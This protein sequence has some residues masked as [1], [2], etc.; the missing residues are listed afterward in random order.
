MRRIIIKETRPGMVAARTLSAASQAGD[1]IPIA[2]AGEALTLD[3]LLRCHE[4][5]IYDLWVTDPGLEFCDELC[6]QPTTPQVRLADALRDS[7]LRLSGCLSRSLFKR[8]SLVMQEIL[9]S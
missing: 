5:G 1:K 2:S 3:H 6:S 7:F 4:L 9:Q 8:Y